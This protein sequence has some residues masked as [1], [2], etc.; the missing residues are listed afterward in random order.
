MED[1]KFK[2]KLEDFICEQCGAEVLGDGYTNHCPKCLWGKHVDVNP[3][4]RAEG[5]GGS[6]EPISVDIKEGVHIL[7]HKCEK[8]GYKRRNKVQRTDDFSIV[9]ELS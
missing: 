7:L 9:L 1:K 8:C 5:C 2:K 4:D 3:G 6:M